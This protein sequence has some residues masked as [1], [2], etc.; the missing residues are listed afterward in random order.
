MQSESSDVGS[1]QGA[2]KILEKGHSDESQDEH[3]SRKRNVGQL[4]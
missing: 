2:K 3:Q 4:I 1:D